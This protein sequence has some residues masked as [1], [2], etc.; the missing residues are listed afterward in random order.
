MP[1]S[2]PVPDPDELDRLTA[3]LAEL[4]ERVVP[5]VLARQERRRGGA[6]AAERLSTP[7]HLTLLALADGPLTMSVLA[8]ATGVALSTATRMVQ[9]L[10][11]E[12]W[13]AP[14][15]A[16]GETDRRRRPVG[17][18][19]EGREVMDGASAIL[20]G[21]LRGLLSHLEPAERASILDG[22][23]ALEKA[24]QLDEERRSRTAQ[25][26]SADS[27]SAGDGGPTG[28]GDAPSGRMPSRITPR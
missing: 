21:R 12:G 11:R 20:R 2:R 22:V 15:A 1:G 7:Q 28:S 3:A 16:P 25:S 23:R 26:S 9:S 19:P 18:T 5:L 10:A 6:T 17:L 14:A 27:T 4:R 8:A 13:V 24:I